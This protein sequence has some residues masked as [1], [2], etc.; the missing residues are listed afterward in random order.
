VFSRTTHFTDMINA[1]IKVPESPEVSA[2]TLPPSRASKAANPTAGVNLI[3]APSANN[4]GN[5]SLVIPLNLPAGRN[6]MQPQ[7]S[8]SYNSG[9][10][11]G[12]LGLGWNVQMPAV[13]IDTRWGVPRYDPVNETE[14]YT[15]NGEQLSPVAHRGALGARSENKRFYPRVE[16]GFSRIIRRGTGP[17]NYWWEVTDKS[18]TRYSYGGTSALDENA[19]PAHQ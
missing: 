1:I 16:G 19:V 14:T 17:G 13:S 15:L 11:N 2:I 12:W 9:G 8:I 6:G 4:T 3:N 5:A 10:G 7:V 18:G